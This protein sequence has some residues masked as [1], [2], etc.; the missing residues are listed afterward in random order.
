[1][2]QVV[3]RQIMVEFVLACNRPQEQRLQ[4]VQGYHRHSYPFR[5]DL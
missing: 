5:H 4:V 2:L 1:M 3:S